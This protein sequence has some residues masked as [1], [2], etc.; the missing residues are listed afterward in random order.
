MAREE[1]MDLK[2][3]PLDVTA[4]NAINKALGFLLS[5]RS[6]LG[7]AGLLGIVDDEGGLVAERKLGARVV[8]RLDELEL[9]IALVGLQN[10]RQ[11]SLVSIP[12]V[13]KR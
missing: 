5:E 6:G 1:K 10:I 4:Y 9:A 13:R 2:V 7:I 11:N 8:G 12:L 3:G